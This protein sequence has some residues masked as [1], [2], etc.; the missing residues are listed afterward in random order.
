M[1]RPILPVPRLPTPLS[2]QSPAVGSW[3]RVDRSYVR[4]DGSVV[5]VLSSQF[6]PNMLGVRVNYYVVID[7]AYTIPVQ[8]IIVQRGPYNR[9]C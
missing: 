3:M 6:H 9:G 7:Q 4:H 1:S 5:I 2:N 8:T